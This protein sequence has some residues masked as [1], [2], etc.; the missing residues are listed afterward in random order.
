MK[1]AHLTI[2][3]LA[4]SAGAADAAKNKYVFVEAKAVPDKPAVAFD[5]AKAYILV[6]SDS[7][8][9][10]MLMKDPTEADIAEYAKLR[11]DAFA[12]VRES[13]ERKLARWKL[14]ADQAAARKLRKPEKPVEPTEANFELTPI[15]LFT[16]IEIGPQNRFA[17]AGR[18]TYLHAVTPGSYRVYG[19]MMF[20]P[21]NGF[22]GT[23][24]CMGSVRFEAKAGEI[25]DLG[26]LEPMPA[27]SGAN[28][29]TMDRFVRPG[30]DIDP[31]LKDFTIRPAVFRPAGKLPNYFGV[32]ISR[33]PAI[34]G[35]MRYDRDRIVD[36]TAA[37]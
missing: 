29:A 16:R 20:L 3:A 34:E 1:L 18:S 28:P 26:T 11:A 25:V 31:R 5:P 9:P 21:N 24:F 37:D 32:T 22:V 14:E 12:E 27:A 17:K 19:Q 8:M 6:R 36:L 13:Y 10:L 30:G 7:M 23:C 33:V 4:L 35:V 15:N 2:A